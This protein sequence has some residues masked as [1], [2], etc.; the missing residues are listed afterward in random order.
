MSN[1]AVVQ[2]VR[3][4]GIGVPLLLWAVLGASG[5]V[6]ALGPLVGVGYTARIVAGGVTVLCLALLIVHTRLSTPR[7]AHPVPDQEEVAH[8]AQD[9]R[10]MRGGGRRRGVDQVHASRAAPA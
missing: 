7:C 2:R 4:G 5:A 1:R 8:A 9:S 10:W 3:G 6:N